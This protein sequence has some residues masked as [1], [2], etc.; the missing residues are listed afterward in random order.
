L[1]LQAASAASVEIARIVPR[2]GG[3]KTLCAL[4]GLGSSA[5]MSRC[6][7]RGWRAGTASHLP[8]FCA[9]LIGNSGAQVRLHHKK[10]AK[11]AAF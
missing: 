10:P 6:V 9:V 2:V 8:L 4:N 1:R 7:L 11:S 3:A 5:A